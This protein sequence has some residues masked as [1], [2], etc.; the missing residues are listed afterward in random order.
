MQKLKREETNDAEATLELWDKAFYENLQ[1][2]RFYQ[3]DEEQI[4]QYFPT[5][6]VTQQTLSIYQ[7]LLGLN[8]EKLEG[9]EV[10]HPDVDVYEVTDTQ[11]KRLLGHFYLDL[12]PR[13]DKYG[14]AAVFPLIK[15]MDL[16]GDGDEY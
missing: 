7:E 10:W 12:F 16:G 9:V 8:F 11:T 15:R 5:T 6:H 1:K 13:D 3:V 4:K 14:H 2:E